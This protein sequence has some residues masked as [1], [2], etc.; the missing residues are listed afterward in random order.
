MANTDFFTRVGAPGTATTLTAPGHAIGGTTFNVVSTSNWP[1]TTSAIFAVDIFDLATGKRVPDSYTEWQGD[2]TSTSA[3]SNAVIRFGN[4][5]A[6]PAGTTTRVYIP[7]ASSR[8]NRLVDGLL[9]GHTQSGTHNTFTETAIVPTAAIQDLAV[10]TGKLAANAVT[11]AKITNS[12]I[13]GAKLADNTVTPAKMLG[14]DLFG[15]GAAYT[16]T[17]P[18]A[19]SG[20]FYMQ[21]GYAVVTTNATGDFS[22]NWP[23]PFPNGLLTTVICDGDDT[24][25]INISL[26]ASA[27]NANALAGSSNK[28]SSQIRVSYIAIG[29]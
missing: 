17:V 29:F 18:T 3:I 23:A 24:G 12:T 19:G 5:K 14:V 15:T 10:T 13:T 1:T 20:Q 9:V 11:D 2:V 22:F 28:I 4:D 6:Y 25:N 8:E 26:I 27:T 16:G 7:V 21:A